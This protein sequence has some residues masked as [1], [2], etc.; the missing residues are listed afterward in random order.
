MDFHGNAFMIYK[1]YLYCSIL[2]KRNT[3]SYTWNI[4]VQEENTVDRITSRTPP[5]V[6]IPGRIRC[7]P[8]LSKGGIIIKRSC[9]SISIYIRRIVCHVVVFIAKTMG[10][11]SISGFSVNLISILINIIKVDGH[12]AP[13]TIPTNGIS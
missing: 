8:H 1:V 3:F 2:I 5:I 9:K 7:K 10:N 12:R 4:I 6:V 13:S 11:R